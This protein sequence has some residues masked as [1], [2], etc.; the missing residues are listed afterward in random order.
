MHPV[1]RLEMNSVYI[2]HCIFYVLNTT[3]GRR[4]CISLAEWQLEPQHNSTIHVS[5]TISSPNPYPRTESNIDIESPV[6]PDVSWTTVGPVPM[7]KNLKFRTTSGS[8]S[9]FLYNED[10]AGAS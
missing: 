8:S 3:F 2:I 4:K 1:T 7:K 5:W 9:F 6:W 10:D